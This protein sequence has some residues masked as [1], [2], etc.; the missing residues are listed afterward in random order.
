MKLFL[1]A[2]NFASFMSVGRAMPGRAVPD[3]HL[4]QSIHHIR[5]TSYFGTV[6]VFFLHKEGMI[7][8]IGSI[9]SDYVVFIYFIR[10]ITLVL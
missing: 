6:R 8:Q 3:D 2:I 7:M 10:T 1:E 9:F 5:L 4:C